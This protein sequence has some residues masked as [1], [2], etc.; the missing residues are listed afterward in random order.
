MRIVRKSPCKVNLLLNIL[1]RRPD[2]FH[3]LET[4][5]LPIPVCDTLD[6]ERCEDP[7]IALTCSHPS[8]PT[9]SGNL[10]FRA[11]ERFLAVLGS[12]VG[13]RIHLEK[14]I[15]LAAGLGGGS[16]NAANVLLALNELFGNPL[17]PGVVSS[18]SAELGSDIPFFLQTG[19][20]L[21]TGRGEQI[22]VLEPFDSLAGHSVLLI[23]PGFGVSTAWAYAQL[24]KSPEL[25]NGAPGRAR[26]LIERLRN[27]DLQTAASGFYNSLESPV[28]R[29][30]PVLA[31][32]QQFLRARFAAAVLM[33]GSGSSTFAVFPNESIARGAEEEFVEQF[34]RACWTAV[35]PL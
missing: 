10:V 35:V 13:L 32:Y 8:L 27:E 28:L 19:P 24:A 34:G 1:G 33:S 11:A 9:D 12:D 30:Y 14:K 29:K 22:E 20:A 25:L 23:H 26:S 21:A 7:G 18:I 6:V 4:L 17:E 2:G 31:E 3:E 16:G 5:M 15:P